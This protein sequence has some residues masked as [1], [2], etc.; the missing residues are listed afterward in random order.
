MTDEYVTD[1]DIGAK[2][3]PGAT[4]PFFAADDRHALLVFNVALDADGRWNSCVFKFV[5]NIVKFGAPSDHSI[6]RHALYGKGLKYYSVGEV[7]N[8]KWYSEL[9][10]NSDPKKTELRHLIFTFHDSTFECLARDIEF[11]IV[12]GEA[13]GVFASQVNQ[14]LL[15]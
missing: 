8:S 2:V 11:S 15:V 13:L 14:F 3:E 1:I 10:P 9:F 5:S 12:A 4:N 6:S 7:H